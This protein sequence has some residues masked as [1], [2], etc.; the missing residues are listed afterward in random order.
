MENDKIKITSP[1]SSVDVSDA[2]N[3]NV[4]K[5][6]LFSAFQE[7][8]LN[9][10][11]MSYETAKDLLNSGKYNDWIGR[12]LSEWYGH[13]ISYDESFGPIKD[14]ID[15]DMIEYF[16]MSETGTIENID[17][18]FLRQRLGELE[19]PK[20][21]GA[22]VKTYYLPYLFK[23]VLPLLHR[24]PTAADRRLILAYC[25]FFDIIDKGNTSGYKAIT[26]AYDR[27]NSIIKLIRI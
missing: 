20:D 1:K 5:N 22:P 25:N 19:K 15:S 4:I 14:N 6:G 17:I 21:K 23:E 11:S 26:S 3:I 12:V 7:N 2:R 8:K 18:N 16:I 10:I 13:L 9:E 27:Y 24:V